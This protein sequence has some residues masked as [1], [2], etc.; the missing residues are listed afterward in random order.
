[1][2]RVWSV[3]FAGESAV[4]MDRFAGAAERRVWIVA[5]WEESEE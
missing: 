4:A 2:G 5:S 1:M 3:T